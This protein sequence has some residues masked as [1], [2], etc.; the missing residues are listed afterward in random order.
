MVSVCGALLCVTAG[1]IAAFDVSLSAT[2]ALFT[3]GSLCDAI[4]G[5][6]ARRKGLAN[7]RGAVVDSCS[8]KFGEAGLFV[9]L[10][11]WGPGGAATEVV[12]AAFTLGFLSSYLKT[13]SERENLPVTWAE[14][15]YFGRAG[16]ATL[17][18]ATLIAAAMS[19]N[20]VTT[21][22]VGFI[23]VGA[24]NAASFLWRLR[25]V[26]G[27]LREDHGASRMPSPL[28]GMNGH[29]RLAEPMESPHSAGEEGM[30]RPV[31]GEGVVK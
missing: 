21:L 4:D 31:Q 10:V 27:A 9:G 22:L 11:V 5:R 3:V 23:L 15:R 26:A 19:A 16:R 28:D 20:A 17:L 30:P 6:L 7:R 13:E 24:F 18:S 1:A 14:A 25:K 2:A 29:S 12:V 8:D